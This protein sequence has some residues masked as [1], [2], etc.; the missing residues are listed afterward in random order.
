MYD[1]GRVYAID[2]ERSLASDLPVQHLLDLQDYFGHLS[3]TCSA[4]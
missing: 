2:F 3:G 1:N 4:L